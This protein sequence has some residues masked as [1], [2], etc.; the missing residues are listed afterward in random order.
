MELR[1]E[2][3]LGA[4]HVARGLIKP[5][6]FSVESSSLDFARRSIR[7]RLIVSRGVVCADDQSV[8][9]PVARL[10]SPPD[11][12]DR[13]PLF[14]F[15]VKEALIQMQ[16]GRCRVGKP[17]N[18]GFGA[19][20]NRL[21]RGGRS[22]IFAIDSPFCVELGGRDRGSAFPLCGVSAEFRR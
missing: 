20:T 19:K 14:D 7:D 3:G 12:N 4:A 22:L 11:R 6:V 18:L 8:R 16:N 1:R 17:L 13:V 10:S 5:S 15:A 21:L 9:R 2:L